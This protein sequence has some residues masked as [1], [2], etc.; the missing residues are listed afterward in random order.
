L[1]R[2]IGAGS[3]SAPGCSQ[4]DADVKKSMAQETLIAE[5]A[6]DGNLP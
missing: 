5:E 2:S 3:G 1:T 6:F 4:P